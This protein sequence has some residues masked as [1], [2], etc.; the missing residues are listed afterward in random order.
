MKIQTLEES[1]WLIKRHFLFTGIINISIT[2]ICLQLFLNI[3]S[4]PTFFSTFLSQMINT[5]I[6][7]ILYS[8]GIFKIQRIFIPYLF[9]KFNLLMISLWFFN[10]LGINYLTK[11]G[12][13]RNISAL[14]LVPPLASFSFLVQRFW[15]FK[16]Y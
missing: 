12:I 8:K 6:G 5:I 4:F 9:F 16:S 2:N 7:Y 15:V 10:Y 1:Y 13:S 14:L 3:E 11:F